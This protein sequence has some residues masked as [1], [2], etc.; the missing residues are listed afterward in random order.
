MDWWV[1]LK[2]P[3]G[4]SASYMDARTAAGA[5]VHGMAL[6][7]SASPLALTLA[8]LQAP[9]AGPRGRPAGQQ[10]AGAGEGLAYAL[11]NDE[12]PPGREW[13]LSAHAKGVA[14]F[15]ASGGFW[16]VHSAPRFPAPPSEGPGFSRLMPPQSVFGQV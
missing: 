14:A 15:G 13:W 11:Y 16:L 7:A 12:D 8:V 6:N 10:P 2:A 3:K 9:P 1:L 4:Y 5:W